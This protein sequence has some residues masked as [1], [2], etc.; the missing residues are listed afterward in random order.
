M[1][2]FPTWIPDF[3]S[4]SSAL[5]D[6]FLSSD[7][8]ICSTMSFPSLRN[9]D[10]I[11]V[12]VS[13]DFPINSQQDDLFLRK[14]Y[15]YSWLVIVAKEFLKLPNLHMLLKQKSLSLPRNLA[16][17]TFCELLIV[18]WTKVNLL[19]LLYSTDQRCFFSASDKAKWFA[20]NFSKNSNLDDPGISLPVFS[21][22][23]NL[24]LYSI[25]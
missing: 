8:R 20:E 25:S 6:L 9:S 13:I 5:L 11:V 16:L 24:K 3:D 23:T 1:V 2:N 12:S 4:H 7:A 15:D 19:Y 22:R 18:F 10:Y 17:G 14:T 21:S